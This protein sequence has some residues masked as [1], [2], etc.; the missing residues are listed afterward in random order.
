LWPYIGLGDF[1]RMRKTGYGKIQIFAVNSAFPLLPGTRGE[2]QAI[3]F[4]PLSSH[5]TDLASQASYLE[6]LEISLVISDRKLRSLGIRTTRTSK[7]KRNRS[8][9]KKGRFLSDGERFLVERRY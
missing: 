1:S 6:L 4:Q 8:S 7:R 3:S 2:L 5:P 9:S